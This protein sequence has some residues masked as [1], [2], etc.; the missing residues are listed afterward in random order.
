[1]K[2]LAFA[3]FL[4]LPGVL[5]GQDNDSI[6]NPQAEVDSLPMFEFQYQGDRFPFDSG[7][8]I[9]Y[10]QYDFIFRKTKSTKIIEKHK[11][12]DQ[13]PQVIIIPAEEKQRVRPWVWAALGTAA[14]VVLR[15]LL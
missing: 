4:L 5:Y 1:M 2:N 15:S 8:A 9:S 10:P 3:F 7:V 11:D 6:P 13:P 14:G 12:A